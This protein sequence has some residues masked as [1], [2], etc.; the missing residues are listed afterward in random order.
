MGNFLRSYFREKQYKEL[1]INIMTF[2]SQYHKYKEFINS[3]LGN[4]CFM[5]IESSRVFYMKHFY[6]N[7]EFLC[8]YFQIPWDL[9][10][11]I[12]YI[13][14]SRSKYGK[15]Y[16]FYEEQFEEISLKL[17]ELLAPVILKLKDHITVIENEYWAIKDFDLYNYLFLVK[18][19]GELD[20]W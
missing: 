12:Y 16:S 19:N 9:K 14:I 2:I 7:L 3:N 20:A 17:N 8:K 6:Q 4:D 15:N 5:G 13:E 11:L 1:E 10:A 18:P